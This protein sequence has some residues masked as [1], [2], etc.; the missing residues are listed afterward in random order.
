MGSAFDEKGGIHVFK[1]VLAV[2]E[3]GP[4]AASAFRL[5]G[6]VAALFGGAVEAVHYPTAPNTMADGLVGGMSGAVIAWDEKRAEER[7]AA[8]KAAFDAALAGRG[9]FLAVDRHDIDDLM[10]RLRTSDVTVLGRPGADPDNASPATAALALHEPA[11]PVIVAPPSGALTALNEI[12]VAWNA[13]AQ[14]ANAVRLAMPLLAKAKKVTIVSV[15]S[16]AH[17]VSAARLKERLARHG[18]AAELAA[19]DPGAVSARARGRAVLGFAHDRAASMLVMGAYGSNQ[20]LEFLGLGGATG[21]IISA[22][23]VPVFVSH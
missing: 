14:A 19:I 15:G 10:L 6:D 2:S 21:K 1:S 3:G 16:N 13:S 8:S 12:V 20:M 9:E 23:K 17:P 18:V 22:C 5:A 4:E 7:A 11:T